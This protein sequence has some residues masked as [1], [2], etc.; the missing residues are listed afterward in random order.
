MVGMDITKVLR[1]IRDK[2]G[3]SQEYMANE[4]HIS[5]STYH[6]IEAGEIRL[7]VERA[8]QLAKLYHIESSYF[9]ENTENMALPIANHELEGPAGIGAWQREKEFYDKLI[10]EKDQQINSLQTELS[11]Y[12]EKLL[13]LIHRIDGK[14][15]S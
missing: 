12:R 3:Y 7:P 8:K 15:Q 11:I 1:D 10:Y 13:D 9:L 5:Q 6:K 2:Y 4:L 14:L